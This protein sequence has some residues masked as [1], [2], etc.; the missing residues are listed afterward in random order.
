VRRR[1]ALLVLA[2]PATPLRA[3]ETTPGLWPWDPPVPWHVVLEW[4][5]RTPPGSDV[6]RVAAAELAIGRL[7]R[8][9]R[10][11]AL[12]AVAA[13][14]HSTLALRAALADAQGAAAGAA[15]LY[16]RAAGAASS[17]PRRAG[18]LLARAGAAHAR[19]GADSAG[20]AAFARARAL[21]PE[22]GGWLALR[23]VPL[24]LDPAAAE[25]L[26]ALAP[27][28]ARPLSLRAL[29]AVRL[30]T[31]DTAGAERFWADGGRPDRAAGLALLRGDTAGARAY[32]VAA[33]L[34]TDTAVQ[35]AGLGILEGGA[36]AAPGAAEDWRA[37]AAAAARLGEAARAAR[38]AG[39]AVAEGDSGPGALVRWGEYLERAGRRSDAMLAYERAGPAG[40]FPRARARLRAG[41]RI[42]AVRALRQFAEAA[43]DDPQAPLALYLAADEAGGD[44][45]LA[46]V[47]E[48]WP[49]HEYGARVR[50]RLA[51]DHL[52]R[53]DTAG[54]LR[55]FDAGARS[56]ASDAALSRFHAGRLRLARGDPEGRAMLVALARDDSLGYYGFQARAALGLPAPRFA[57]APPRAPAPGARALL[58]ELALLEAAGLAAEAD[59]L[60]ADAADRGWDDPEE[61]LDVADGLTAAGRPVAG[62]RLGWRAATRLTLNHPRV[63]RAVFPWPHRELIEREA[64]E[65]DLDPYLLAGLIRHESGFAAAARSRAGAVGAMQ[66]MPATARE[67]ARRLGLPWSDAMRAVSDANIHVGSAHLAGLFARYRGDPIPTIAAY[68]AGG[69][70]V[71]RWLRTPGAGDRLLFVERIAYPETQGYVRTVWRNGQLYRALYGADGPTGNP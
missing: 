53:R 60:V 41:D 29:A 44:S 65:F 22:I 43:P 38:L 30:R 28:P 12:P 56:G 58:Q 54:A 45:L 57:P 15:D 62:I 7:A 59:L 16:Q 48:R 1:A 9:G 55:Y 2:L 34:A 23:E 3:Q 42:A 26:I 32:S 71:S 64:A 25:L 39:R 36:A 66:L 70:P 40:E 19:A 18:L 4:H 50:Q 13:D 8:V 61:L 21:L 33:V 6:L 17:D 47:A 20:A 35:R 11:L 10:L 52:G 37:A 69:T 51:L 46:A 63:V 5:S 24:R 27:E 68:N 31:G 14:T 67:L 49:A